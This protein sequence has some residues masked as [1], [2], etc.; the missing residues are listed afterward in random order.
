MNTFPRFVSGLIEID[1][2][3]LIG[4]IYVSGTIRPFPNTTSIVSLGTIDHP[5]HQIRGESDCNRF[6]EVQINSITSSAPI[7]TN[8]QNGIAGISINYDSTLNVTPS[9][10]LSVVPKILMQSDLEMK[11]TPPVKLILDS[12]TDPLD[13]IGSNIV[14]DYDNDDL[15]IND[16]GKLKTILL[17]WKGMGALKVGGVTDVEFLDIFY[18]GLSDDGLNIPKLTSIRLC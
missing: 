15:Y 12:S 2:A 8:T 9:R 17:T 16:E 7:V 5:F 4:T 3:W 18:D 13:P 11:A 14:L 1:N 10:Q 6:G